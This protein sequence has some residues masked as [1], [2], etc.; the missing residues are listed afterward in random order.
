[1]D[2]NPIVTGSKPYGGSEGGRRLDEVRSKN[3]GFNKNSSK[4]LKFFKEP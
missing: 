4:I 1:M 2:V 3:E